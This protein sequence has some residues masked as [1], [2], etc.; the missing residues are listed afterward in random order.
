[1]K[2]IICEQDKDVSQFSVEHVIP[3]AIGGV[4]T[5]DNVCKECNSHLGTEVDIHLINHLLFDIPVL[6]TKLR[7]SMGLSQHLYFQK[8]L[9][10]TDNQK[11]L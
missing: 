1:M 10:A 11:L 2:C 4:L 9:D 3:E 5:I 6:Y 7:T 8:V